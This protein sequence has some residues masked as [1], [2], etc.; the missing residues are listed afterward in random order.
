VKDF[1]STALPDHD[2]RPRAVAA[3]L[4]SIL[5]VAV[6]AVTFGVTAAPG[7]DMA[8][9]ALPPPPPPHQKHPGALFEDDFQDGKLDG[10]TPDRPGVWSI[11][12]G[13]LRADLPDGRQLRSFLYAGSEAW[14][15]VSVDLDVCGMRGVDKGVAVRVTGKQGIGID[16]RGPGYQDLVVY[17]R[18]WPMGRAAVVN[19]NSVW[20]HLHVEVRGHRYRVWVNG[21]LLVDRDDPHK[22]YPAGRIALPAYTGGVGE[23]T[24]YYDNIVVMPLP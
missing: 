11:T 16:L 24:V 8:R 19:A 1:S 15:D 9:N 6:C 7:D 10:W 2:R 4:G 17:R 18:D 5:F 23:C 14:T 12:H 3:V 13:V 21:T 20:H 22:S